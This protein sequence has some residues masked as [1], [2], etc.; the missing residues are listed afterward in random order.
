MLNF[1]KRHLGK[2]SADTKATAYLLKVWPVM[3]YACIV[4]DPHY[5]TQVSMLEKVQRWL[6][7]IWL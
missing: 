5:Q 4:W 7:P 3:E 6:G 1:I 2:C